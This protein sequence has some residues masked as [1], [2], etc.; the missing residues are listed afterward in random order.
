MGKQ[1]YLGFKKTLFKGEKVIMIDPY[2]E[3]IRKF[4]KE[5]A[6]YIIIGVSGINYYARDSRQII[7]TADYDIFLKPELKNIKKALGIM[8][9]LDYTLIVG[10]R[11]F[12]GLQNNDLEK[13][14]KKRRTIV[15]E[16]PEH[17]LIELCLE[18]SGYSFEEL[19]RNARFFKAGKD[20]IQVAGLRDLLRMKM[21]AGREKDKLFLQ[22]Y[23]TLLKSDLSS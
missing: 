4:N 9:S 5:K 14:I 22:K 19:K 16:N 20:K 18:V 1:N 23:S 11:T 6:F 8:R 21:L 17:N 12:T 15:C 2:L 13:L 7:M 10:N 3:I